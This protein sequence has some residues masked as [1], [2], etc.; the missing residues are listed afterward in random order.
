MPEL[1][2]VQTV[3]SDL[4]SSLKNTVILAVDSFYQGTVIRDPELDDNALPAKITAYERRGKYIIIHLENQHS[5][6]VH[7]RMTGK[8]VLQ[9]KREETSEIHKH[10]RACFLLSQEQKLLFIDPRTFGKI[11]LC[12]TENLPRYI[13]I[14]G[15][16]PLTA[17]FDEKYLAAKLKTKK[18]PIKTALLDQS[19]V[20]GLGNIYVC[21]ILYRA[22]IRP[23][24]ASNTITLSKLKEI[25][26]HTKSVLKEA[27]AHNGTSISDYRRVDDKSG[28]FQHFLKVYQKKTCPLGHKIENIRLSGRSSFYCPICQKTFCSPPQ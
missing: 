18:S 3:L 8:L 25:V 6:I 26:K 28:E 23:D 19:V 21:E 22:G 16:E 15:A 7:L 12:K 10:Q 20:A 4:K 9:A 27:I 5:I 11:T 17:A 14:L 1:P 2:E 13:A 24:T